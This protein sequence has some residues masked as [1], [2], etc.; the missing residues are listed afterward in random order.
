MASTQHDLVEGVWAQLTTTDKAGEVFHLDGESQVIYSES[1]AQPVG[2]DSLTPTS[3]STGFRSGFYYRE[4]SDDDLLW[5]LALTGNVTLTVTPDSLPSIVDN[6]GVPRDVTRKLRVEGHNASVGGG[7]VWNDIWEGGAVTIPEPDQIA[8]Q[9]L[10]VVSSSTSDTLAGTGGQR[11]RIDFLAGGEL[12]FE[13]LDLDGQTPVLTT[14]TNIT[15][16]IDFY[17]VQVGATEIAVGDIDITD[18]GNDSVIYNRIAVGGNKSMSTLRHLLPGDTFYI[19]DLV[20][21]GDT[22]GTEVILRSDSSDAGIVYPNVYLFAV[23]VT[24]TDAPSVIRFEPALE[25][26]GPARL[27]VSARAG[28]SGNTVSVFMNGYVKIS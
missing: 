5:G 27:K 2:H 9:Q 25:I 28:A 23:P 26:P 4:I 13:E 21:S 6:G 12:V 10:Q 11:V 16:I 18:V 22:K 17:N 8:G 19:T 3:R 14:A 7:N 1:A 24:M 15:D 20:L